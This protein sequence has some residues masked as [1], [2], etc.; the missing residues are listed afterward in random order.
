MEE[1][2]EIVARGVRVFVRAAIAGAALALVG[3]VSFVRRIPSRSQRASQL[4]RPRRRCLSP[5]GPR[6]PLTAARRRT[7]SPLGSQGFKQ[8]AEIDGVAAGGDRIR[9]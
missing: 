4:R 6:R 9:R 5:S 7:A 8:E 2:T 1:R 3:G